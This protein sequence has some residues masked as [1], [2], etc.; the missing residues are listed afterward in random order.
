MSPITIVNRHAVVHIQMVTVFLVLLVLNFSIKVQ[1]G[2]YVGRDACT[3]CHA[4]QVELW[5][6]SHHDL[7]MQHANDETVL[8]DF[9]NTKFT[10]AGITSAFYKKNNKFL[11]RT[12][13]P[14][15]KLHDYE[16]KYAFGITPLQQY[17]VELEKGDCRR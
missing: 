9:S 1:A 13:G 6:G 8:A 2:E 15:G 10:Y 16:I 17:L 14:D 5:Q 12:D 11:V 3:Q 7:A 4:K